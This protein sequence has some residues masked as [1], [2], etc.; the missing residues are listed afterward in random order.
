MEDT[1]LLV[2]GLRLIAIFLETLTIHLLLTKGEHGNTVSLCAQKGEEPDSYVQP[3]SATLC[4]RPM[5]SKPVVRRE[6][7]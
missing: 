4:D 6:S 3:V 5:A 1:H 7:Y 2:E